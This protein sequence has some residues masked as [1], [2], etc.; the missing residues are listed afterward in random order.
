M[1]VDLLVFIPAVRLDRL[2]V[3]GELQSTFGVDEKGRGQADEFIVCITVHPAGRGIGFHH[4]AGLQ[5]SDDQPIAGGFEDPLI[6]LFH[7]LNLI[8][9]GFGYQ[10]AALPAQLEDLPSRPFLRFRPASS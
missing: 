9:G 5:I 6:L 10:F 8:E 4:Q 2:D 1:R 3:L 7:S